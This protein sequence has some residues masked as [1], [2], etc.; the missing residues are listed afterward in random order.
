MYLDLLTLIH[1]LDLADSVSPIQYAIR[2]LIP[3]GSRLMELPD[4]QRLVQPFNEE[5]LCYPWT[6]PDPRVDQLCG[7]VLNLVKSC[8]GTEESRHTIF[9]KVWQLAADACGVTRPGGS[10]GAWWEAG[11][12]KVPVPYLSE[13]W[14]C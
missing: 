1:D 6:H 7:D 5:G 8:Q 3:S 12:G 4:V 10:N 9:G 11:P 13:P 2:L 14:Y